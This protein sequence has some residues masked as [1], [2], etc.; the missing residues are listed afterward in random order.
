MERVRFNRLFYKRDDGKV[1]RVPGGGLEG[2]YAS[3][4]YEERRP[5][6]DC[7]SLFQPHYRVLWVEVAA[8]VK[9]PWW[10]LLCLIFSYW[11]VFCLIGRSV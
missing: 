11:P 10:V 1:G 6:A 2:P 3:F 9:L 5:A 7:Y 4:A 8:Y